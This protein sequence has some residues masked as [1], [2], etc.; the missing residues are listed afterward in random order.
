MS[1]FVQQLIT[2]LIPL[3]VQEAEQLLGVVANPTDASW[4]ASLV[5]EIAK[6]VESFIPSWLAPS[7]QEIEQLVVAELEKILPKV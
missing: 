1:T 6:L 5:A 4:V 3:L 2:M 7:L